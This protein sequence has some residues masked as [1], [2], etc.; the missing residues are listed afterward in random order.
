MSSRSRSNFA[1]SA[2]ESPS[3]EKSPERPPKAP[4]CCGV[5]FGCAGACSRSSPFRDAAVCSP[6][7][8]SR[9]N[10]TNEGI[11]GVLWGWDETFE[12]AF[13]SIIRSMAR[14]CAAKEVSFGEVKIFPPHPENKPLS[15]K[16]GSSSTI[17]KS[18]TAVSIFSCRGSLKCGLSAKSNRVRS[19]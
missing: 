1:P 10:C 9:G 18:F 11:G 4:C 12:R 5:F 6:A 19:S 16:K 3:E 13:I 17:F 7:F 8:S 2:D 14:C 15:R